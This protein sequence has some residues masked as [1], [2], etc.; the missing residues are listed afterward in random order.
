MSSPNTL[1]ESALSALAP[2]EKL[3][4]QTEALN[5]PAY[6]I[7]VDCQ[8]SMDDLRAAINA[9]TAIRAALAKEPVSVDAYGYRVRGYSDNLS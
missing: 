4:R 3:F 7:N 5:N 6:L 2:M 9:A 1:L 8:V